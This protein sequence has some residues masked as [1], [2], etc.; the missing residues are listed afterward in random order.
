M[1]AI[2]MNSSKSSRRR[3]ASKW[4]CLVA[5]FESIVFLKYFEVFGGECL[6][7][8]ESGTHVQIFKAWQVKLSVGPQPPADATEP[9][10]Y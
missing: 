5:E 9:P 4:P 10:S 2:M 1:P 6:L 8:V 3:C 7:Q